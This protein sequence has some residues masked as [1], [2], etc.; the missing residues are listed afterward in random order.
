MFDCDDFNLIFEE[1]GFLLAIIPV[2]NAIRYKVATLIEVMTSLGESL[3]FALKGVQG[4][5][6]N[7]FGN[8]EIRYILWCEYLTG[9]ND[10][11]PP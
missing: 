8:P 3:F 5:A 10:F 2:N 9:I 7:V 4:I 1:Y 6:V 11:L